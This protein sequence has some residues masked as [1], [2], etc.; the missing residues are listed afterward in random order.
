MRRSRLV[1][2][3]AVVAAVAAGGVGGALI[4]VPALSG[5]QQFPN[6]AVNVAATGSTPTSNAGRPGRGPALLEAAAKALNLTPEQLRQKLSDGKT[7]IADVAKQQNVDVQ[8]VID[9]MA[10]ADKD[11][12]QGIVNNPWPKFG[13]GPGLGGRGMGGAGF[14]PGA[15]NPKGGLGFAGGLGGGLGRIGA[16]VFDPVAKALGI[17]TDELKADL[18]K[19]QTIADIAKSK[20]LD[21]NQV[22]DTLVADASKAI[23]TAVTDGHLKQAQADKIKAALKTGITK[24]VNDGFKG[25]KG[26]LGGFGGRHGFG[27]RMGGPTS[28]PPTTTAPVTP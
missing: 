20:N 2:G 27:G 26:A 9:A 7:T 21:V 11:R 3:I 18:A 19:G 6:S 4:G 16:L 12:I 25:A 10:A 14:G 5:A 15:P 24:I 22:I 23:D 28:T 8:T 1:T 17:T 13:G